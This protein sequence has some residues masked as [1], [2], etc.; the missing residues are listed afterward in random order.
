MRAMG[1]VAKLKVFDNSELHLA[2]FL[3]A[4][5]MPCTLDRDYILDGQII[6]HKSDAVSFTNLLGRT[7]GTLG[8]TL[9][10]LSDKQCRAHAEEV[11][12]GLNHTFPHIPCMR[13]FVESVRT[14]MSVVPMANNWHEPRD[15]DAPYRLSENKY[16]RQ[17]HPSIGPFLANRYGFEVDLS[18]VCHEVRNGG[19]FEQHYFPLV[20]A[21]VRHDL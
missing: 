1:P 7:F 9:Y 6:M 18:T 21:I 10:E 20:D 17:P 16:V 5:P 3:S 15:R 14:A 8:W 13:E 2:S 4:V 12:H 11:L 19:P